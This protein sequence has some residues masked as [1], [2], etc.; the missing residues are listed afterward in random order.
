MY[1]LF[2]MEHRGGYIDQINWEEMSEKYPD[3]FQFIAVSCYGESAAPY[4][5]VQDEYGNW[6]F[7]KSVFEGKELRKRLFRISINRIK[8]VL[9]DNGIEFFVYN[10]Y[11]KFDTNNTLPCQYRIET[12]DDSYISPKSIVGFKNAY[13]AA[14]KK[15]ILELNNAL[16]IQRAM[17]RWKMY[18]AA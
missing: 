5:A 17:Y 2:K 14:L 15:A 10:V 4:R 12:T 16:E 1:K 7:E 18:E 11:R 6:L 3:L 13:L 9:L 8:D